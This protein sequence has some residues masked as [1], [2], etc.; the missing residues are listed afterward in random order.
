MSVRK[1]L[2]GW[3][4]PF[5]DQKRR[6]VWKAGSLCLF[7]TMWKARNR[8]AF[9][10]EE[11]SIQRLKS[12]FVSYLWS[13]E[14]GYFHDVPLNSFLLSRLVGPLVRA[15][16]LYFFFC[17]LVFLWWRLVVVVYFSHTLGCFFDNPF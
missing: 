15:G 16:W 6:K 3:H 8:I 7:W 17:M 9:E 10:G 5:V 14:K 4:G 1:T 2:L 11:L 12:S 13:E